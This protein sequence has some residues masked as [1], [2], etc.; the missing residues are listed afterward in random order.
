MWRTA[1]GRDLEQVVIVAF[2]ADELEGVGPSP[3]D[4]LELKPRYSDG[5]FRGAP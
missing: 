1:L 5:A 3:S 2:G 4:T